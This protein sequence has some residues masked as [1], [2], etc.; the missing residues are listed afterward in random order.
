MAKSIERIEGIG[1]RYG[2]LF[3]SAGVRTV[4]DLLSAGADRRLRLS[5]SE[6][7]SI[8]EKTILRFVNM[9]DLFRINGV[10]SQYAELLECAGVDTVKELRNRNPE[11]LT[12]AMARVNAQKNVVRRTP[13]VTVVNSWITQAKD[14]APK[15]S[16]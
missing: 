13:S 9:A 4:E 5:L 11:N 8:S 3:R 7:T 16:Y 6:K 10:A 1:P 15:V 2:A 12:D 14:L